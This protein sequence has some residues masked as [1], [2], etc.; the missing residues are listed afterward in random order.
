MQRFRR[1]DANRDGQLD[2]AEIEQITKRRF[3][4]LDKNA[5][6]V[7]TDDER[8]AR[9]STKTDS[10]SNAAAAPKRDNDVRGEVTKKTDG[11]RLRDG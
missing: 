11:D 1:L 5:D 8:P 10:P 2:A 7:I 9:N 4:A 3:A 6:G